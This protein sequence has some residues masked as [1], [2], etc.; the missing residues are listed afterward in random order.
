MK[1]TLG[2]TGS[3]SAY[4][5]I[6]LLRL[7]VKDGHEVKVVLTKGAL[8][9]VKAELFSYLGASEVFTSQ[10]D[11]KFP[12]DSKSQLNGSVLHVEL[13]KWSDKLVIAPLCANTLSSFVTAQSNDLLTSLFLAWPKEKPILS[14]PAMN[15]QMYNHPFVKDNL[16]RL[17]ELE[18]TY[19]AP[20]LHGE[21]ACG[22]HGAGKLLEV[23]KIYNLTLSLNPCL[24]SKSRKN[25]LLTTGATVAPLDSVR[26]VTNASSGKTALPFIMKALEKGHVVVAV[27]GIYATKELDLFF[28]HPNFTLIRV[29]TAQEMLQKVNEEFPKCDTYIS[30]AAIGDFHFEAK[31]NK[32]KKSQLSGT[33]PI[34]RSPDILAEMLSQKKDHQVIIGFAAESQLTDEV[35][36]EKMKRKPVDML[37]GT[38]VNSGLIGESLPKGFGTDAAVYRIIDSNHII[39]APLTLN[40]SELAQTVAQKHY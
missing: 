13:T 40:K 18:N 6:E 32:L 37:I 3:I 25:I 2:V 30:M 24:D 36:I 28:D 15:T 33:L 39:T 17:S 16:E 12:H 23:E 8:K 26:F 31:E 9:F 21:L 7:L 27:A 38:E 4:K 29:K 35:L 22:D 20:T 19:V 5:S 14:F 1:I 34:L 11:F 10:D